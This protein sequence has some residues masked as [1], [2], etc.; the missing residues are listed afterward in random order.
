MN[1]QETPTSWKQLKVKT[2]LGTLAS[3]FIAVG[4]IVWQ[5]MGIKS[6]IDSNSESVEEMTYALS[7]LAGAVSLANELDTR[8]NDLFEQIDGL[9]SEYQDQADVWVEISTQASQIDTIQ[10][11]ARILRQDIEST[12]NQQNEFRIEVV[13]RISEFDSA[14]QDLLD[15]EWKV[16]DL[17]RQVAEQFGQDMGNTDID[18]GWQITDL[19][20]QVAE[21]HGRMQ[22]TNDTEWKVDDLE[23]QLNEVRDSVS[24]LLM[25]SEQQYWTE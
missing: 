19:V 18:Y 14:N 13:E 10:K 3:V 6:N 1:E 5:G 12:W 11:E 4:V 25:I 23:R 15:L 9:R 21:L 20:R 2:N 16:D 24:Y 7:E 8:T 17:Q 22:A